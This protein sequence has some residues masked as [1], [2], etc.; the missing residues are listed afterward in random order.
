MTM[1]EK[2]ERCFKLQSPQDI[3]YSSEILQ[4]FMAVRPLRFP[5]RIDKGLLWEVRMR[6]FYLKKKKKA[7]TALLISGHWSLIIIRKNNPHL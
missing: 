3:P 2:Y 4:A 1:K 5:W 6:T 7:E